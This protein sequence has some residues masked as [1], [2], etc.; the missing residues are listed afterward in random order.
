MHTYI[1]GR[2]YMNMYE[3]IYIYIVS[4]TYPTK[5]LHVKHLHPMPA[6]PAALVEAGLQP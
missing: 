2:I 1:R 3:Y 4:C 6:T 5:L